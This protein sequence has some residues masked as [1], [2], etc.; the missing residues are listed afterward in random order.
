M[1]HAALAQAPE[2]RIVAT[3]HPKESYTDAERQAIYDLADANPR[4]SIKT[5]GMDRLLPACDYVV[6]QNSS[7]AFNAMF[8]DKPMILFARSD[9]H[10]L[11]LNV[12]SLG[13]EGAFAR[14]EAP[15]PNYSTYLW[16]F[17][18]RMSINAG[19]PEAED[20]IVAS[21]RRAGWPL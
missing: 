17:W 12:A 18:Q 3:F 15:A 16:W 4:L 20:Q 10:H 1:L 5:G 7:V 14:A 11:A 21:L 9:F 8:F 19:R 2:R 6:T 13:I